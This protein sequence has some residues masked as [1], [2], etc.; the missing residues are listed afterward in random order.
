MRFVV[1]TPGDSLGAP[2]GFHHST[3]RARIRR[4]RAVPSGIARGETPGDLMRFV[5]S[6]MVGHLR[7][8]TRMKLVMMNGTEYM[9]GDDNT[10][11]G[12]V[13]P[14]AAAK[15][16]K[17][18]RAV[19]AKVA[20]T[21]TPKVEAFKTAD[22]TQHTLRVWEYRGLKGGCVSPAVAAAL[23]KVGDAQAIALL[24]EVASH[25]KQDSKQA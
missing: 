25:S 4:W 20:A 2:R 9:V 16:A 7:T 15:A 3:G 6:P 8:E 21:F 17:A 5:V 10:V 14:V 24:R 12:P 1:R 22:G 18:G 13:T 23:L 11:I 19:K